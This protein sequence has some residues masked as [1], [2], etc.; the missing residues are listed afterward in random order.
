MFWVGVTGGIGSGK[1]SAARHLAKRGA[2]L[3]DAD[4]LSAEL[5]APG[6]AAVAGVVERFGTGLLA[7][8]GGL[9]RKAVRSLIFNDASA[10]A[11]YDAVMR[12]LLLIRAKQECAR[13]ERAPGP[14]PFGAFEIPLL[15]EAP[16]FRRLVDRTLVIDC[17]T[18]TQARR[19]LA[20]GRHS[21][22]EI[23]SFLR[24]QT[25]RQDRLSIAQDVYVNEGSLEELARAMDLLFLVYLGLAQGRGRPA[26][27]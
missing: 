20:R 7:H 9:D 5:I 21:E 14:A 18:E 16:A 23:R 24:A 10:K 6:G 2:A 25:S 12:R 13:F 8:D 26:G 3:V 1:S 4:V 27:V 11:E 22:S 19:A 17:E 15:F